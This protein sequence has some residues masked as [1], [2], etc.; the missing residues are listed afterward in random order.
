MDHWMERKERYISGILILYLLHMEEICGR[1]VPF[2]TWA[3]V[4]TGFIYEKK[5]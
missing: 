4:T 2:S 5:C 3:K 1:S